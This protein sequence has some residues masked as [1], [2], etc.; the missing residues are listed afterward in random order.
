MKKIDEMSN[1]ELGEYTRKSYEITGPYKIESW[2]I[3]QLNHEPTLLEIDKVK[4]IFEELG[5][6]DDDEFLITLRAN[7]T[8][9]EN[10]FYNLLRNNT[11]LDNAQSD[12]C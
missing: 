6:N 3:Y 1:E 5:F 7:K 11:R 8:H 2:S 4:M 10:Y 9:M 12:N